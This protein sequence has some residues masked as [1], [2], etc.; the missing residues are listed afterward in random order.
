MFR[1]AQIG[2]NKSENKNMKSDALRKKKEL[3]EIH[4]VK[5]HQTEYLQKK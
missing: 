2:K 5:L 4:K 3:F 1:L